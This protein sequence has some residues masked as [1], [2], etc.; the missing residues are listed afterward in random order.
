M[1][2]IE[3]NRDKSGMEIKENTCD[4]DKLLQHASGKNKQKIKLYEHIHTHKKKM[5]QWKKKEMKINE[6]YTNLT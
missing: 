4:W 6:N 5:R 2:W 1:M 3:T